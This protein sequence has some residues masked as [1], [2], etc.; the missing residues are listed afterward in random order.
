MG[1]EEESCHEDGAR[2]SPSG[3]DQRRDL[4]LCLG[5]AL[6]VA[7]RRCQARMAGELLYVAQAAAGLDDLARRAGDEGS[8]ATVRGGAGK[9]SLPYSR[10]NHT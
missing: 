7:L 1:V 3:S 6:D 8:P 4:A 9:P 10:A 5:I 2:I